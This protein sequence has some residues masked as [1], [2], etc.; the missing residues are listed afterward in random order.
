MGAYVC[1]RLRPSRSL[2]IQPFALYVS[3]PSAD[4]DEKQPTLPLCVQKFEAYGGTTDGVRMVQTAGM[5]WGLVASRD[6]KRDE[7]L[8]LLPEKLQLTYGFHDRDATPAWLAALI[9]Q[10]PED[11]WSARLGLA[12]LRERALGPRSLFVPYVNLLPAVH[13]GL[14]A[15]FRP[16]AVAAMQYPPA[17]EQVKRRGRF[18]V[19]F[20]AGPLLAATTGGS[21]A[22]EAGARDHPASE[23]DA[24][25]TSPYDAAFSTDALPFSGLDV[26]ADALGWATACA[27]SRAF[28]VAGPDHPPAMLPLID[29]AN[30]SFEPTATVRPAF[31]EGVGR[32]AVEL[33]A[34]RDVAA[35]EPVTLDYGALTNDHFLLD[36]GFVP[37]TESG[38]GNPH[39]VAA[40]RWD[41]GL[42]DAAREVA[43]LAAA[44]FGAPPSSSVGGSAIGSEKTPFAPWQ[45][46]A[47]RRLGL[48]GPPGTTR[49]ELLVTRDARS[50]LD[51]RAFAGARILY[52]RSPSDFRR[53]V[54]TDDENDDA[55]AHANLA[56]LSSSSA[57]D[58]NDAM[59]LVPAMGLD[60][61]REAYALRTCQ[62]ALALALGNFPTTLA[63]DARWLA[64]AAAR[65]APASADEEDL[66]TATRFRLG[67][68]E[69]ISGAMRAIDARLREVLA[70]R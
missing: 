7:R 9:E 49:P 14:P 54:I 62:A 33:A 21:G 26:S 69:V 11:L 12:L 56:S 65:G 68:K 52:A 10:V 53:R 31:G 8:V 17:V 42:L 63:E 27:S 55:N 13:R 2:V 3:P 58:P 47:L 37:T 32:G 16:E 64:D 40:L 59:G 46:D 24:G 28:R 30:H 5:G 48:E 23:R 44:P 15:F 38:G 50:P 61:T 6:V 18:L 35:G 41:L 66:I 36:Y 22:G 70:E 57:F 29:V 1:C 51:P 4:T 25:A 20:A 39:D 43:G 60:R 67:K 34:R 19:S 45:A